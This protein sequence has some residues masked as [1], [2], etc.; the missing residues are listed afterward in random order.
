[1]Y[2]R[3]R[4]NCELCR[5]GSTSGP[6]RHGSETNQG[7]HTLEPLLYNALFKYRNQAG[8]CMVKPEIEKQD[9]T[10]F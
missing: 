1:M 4:H 6:L 9:L 3:L 10:S 7:R 8:H 5:P 2:L